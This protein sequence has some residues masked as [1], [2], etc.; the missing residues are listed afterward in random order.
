MHTHS[1]DQRTHS[2]FFLGEKHERN[3]RRTWFVVALTVVMMV[4]EI[5]AGSYFGSMALLADGWHM[6]THAAALGIAGLAYLFARRQAANTHFSFGTGKF[7]DLAAF[8]SALILGII[9]V[10]I[11]Y[12]SVLRLI[13]PVP[14]VYAEAIAVATLGL[15]V[16]L[17]SAFLLRD[18][19]DHH[20]GH[21]H[22]HGHDHRHDDHD[23]DHDHDHHDH[24][25][26]RRH[27]DNNFRAAYVHVL[28]D[29]ATSVLA[30][31]ALVTG[32]YTGWSWADPAVGLVGSVVIASWAYTLIR[33][34]GSVLLDVRFDQKMEGTIR[35]RLEAGDD[36]VTD[37]HVW[38]VGP[39]HCAAVISL[40]SDAPLQPAMYKQRLHDIKG[41]SHVTVEVEQCQHQRTGVC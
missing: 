21:S 19:H 25:H 41:L 37:L 8:S 13:S 17:V 33:D 31:A 12:E 3:E 7:G 16:N 4:G 35:A 5:I 18:S 14:I 38:Q 9:A 26:A 23:H 32:M 6:G 11:A 10:Q 22:A 15:A 28:A 29:A 36:R 34:A 40:V 30:I 20:H 27:R 39:G 1:L 24:A 2:H